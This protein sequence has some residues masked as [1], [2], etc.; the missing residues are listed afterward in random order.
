MVNYRLFNYATDEV[1]CETDDHC[2]N[3]LEKD[4]VSPRDDLGNK[5]IN[6]ITVYKEGFLEGERI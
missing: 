6:F 1:I 4:M 3:Y 5:E 2:T